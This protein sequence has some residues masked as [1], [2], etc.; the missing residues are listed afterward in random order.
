MGEGQAEHPRE[1]VLKEEAGTWPGEGALE[2]RSREQEGWG[3]QISWGLAGKGQ[4]GLTLVGGS[5]GYAAEVSV[6]ASTEA[7][8]DRSAMWSGE[9]GQGA[10]RAK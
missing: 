1:T 10:N 4:E 5:S 3:V 8:E 2:S 7:I 6:S 9:Q